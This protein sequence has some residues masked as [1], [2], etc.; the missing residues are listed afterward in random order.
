MPLT[1]AQCRKAAKP[2]DGEKG[3]K[4]ADAGGLFLFVTPKGGKSW[5]LKY[6]FGGKEKGLRFGLYP[7]V[8]LA[9]A[10][11]LRE[12][13]KRLLRDHKDPATEERKRRMAA[14]AAAGIVFEPVA[15]RWHHAQ[16]SRWSPIQI[17][18]VLQA[19]ERD[20]FPQIGPLPLIDIDGPMVLRMLRRVE[21]RGAIDTAKR[22]R[23]H[24]SAVFQFAMAEG[25]VAVDP[26]AGIKKGLKPTPTGG[27]QPAVKTLPDARA[28]LAVM[29]ASTSD[30]ATKLASR[31]LALTVVRPGVVRAATWS[32]FEGIDWD[33]HEA[34][35]PAALWRVPAA[36]MKLDVENKADEAFEHLVPLPPAAVDVLRQARRLSGRHPYLFHSVRSTHQPMSEN[37]ISYM[38][39]RNGYTGRHVPHGW[40]ATFSTVMNARAIEQ[41][42]PDDRAII[43]A[44]LAHKPTGMS[45]SEMAYNRALHMERRRELAIEWAELLLD[46]LGPASSLMGD[47]GRLR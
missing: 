45:G 23:Q 18:K 9:R 3:Y 25:L 35:A 33:N 12:D 15:R 39:A 44:M 28:L 19:L 42:R 46:G 38:Y 11:E 10:R 29:D 20:V 2:A 16:E 4:L 26:A 1:D 43:D 47:A 13:A 7:D 34:P 5:R 30:A 17:K 40:R 31:L 14:H 41:R 8:S 24:V 27:K 36:R 6:R 37:T 32:E 22:I 21:D